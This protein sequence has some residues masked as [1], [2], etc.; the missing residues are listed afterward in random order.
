MNRFIKICF[1]TISFSLFT[2]SSFAGS[3]D[4]HTSTRSAQDHLKAPCSR[5]PD[6]EQEDKNPY[7]EYDKDIK[8][9]KEVVPGVNLGGICK[10]KHCKANTS[11]V[12]LPV[13][14]VKYLIRNG[15]YAKNPAC[16]ECGTEFKVDGWGFSECLFHIKAKKPSGIV[17]SRPWARAEEKFYLISIPEV[18]KTLYTSVKVKY[19]PENS[20]I[21]EDSDEEW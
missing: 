9:W 3:E 7:I 16:P 5:G 11:Y 8:P 15:K 18:G 17:C 20:A 1:L 6:I 19:L 10:N 2:S 12:Y 14:M 4:K 21:P 13:G